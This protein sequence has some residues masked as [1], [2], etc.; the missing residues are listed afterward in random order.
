[1]FINLSSRTPPDSNTGSATGR[2][3]GAARILEGDVE[4]LQEGVNV[5]LEH[6]RRIQQHG[7]KVIR[8]HIVVFRTGLQ[9]QTSASVL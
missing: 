7:R 3:E 9:T 6:T 5:L 4:L 2:S 1:M 8:S